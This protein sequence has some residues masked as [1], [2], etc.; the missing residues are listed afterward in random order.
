MI[1]RGNGYFLSS[2]RQANNAT[3]LIKQQSE[4]NNRASKNGH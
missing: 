1:I 4:S 2:I 3:E